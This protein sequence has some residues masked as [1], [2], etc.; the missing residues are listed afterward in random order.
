[1][2]GHIPKLEMVKVPD[3]YSAGDSFLFLALSTNSFHVRPMENKS[4]SCALNSKMVKWLR[5]GKVK[6][7]LGLE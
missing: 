7:E 5:A 2:D 1:M 3:V 6:S 4:I